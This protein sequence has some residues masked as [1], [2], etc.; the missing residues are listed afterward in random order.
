MGITKKKITHN[1]IQDIFSEFLKSLY[2]YPESASARNGRLNRKTNR[3][4]IRCLIIIKMKKTWFY[5]L[6]SVN[7]RG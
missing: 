4:L 3:V 6:F 7:P 1:E 2:S 5:Y